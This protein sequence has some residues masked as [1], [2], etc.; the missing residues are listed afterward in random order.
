M[1]NILLGIDMN[2][3]KNM[4]DESQ[5]MKTLYY[6]SEQPADMFYQ[7]CAQ[8]LENCSEVAFSKNQ[9]YIMEKWRS[10]YTH[11]IPVE[12]LPSKESLKEDIIRE[13]P[14]IIVIDTLDHAVAGAFN[15]HQAK[16]D[17]MIA[18]QGIAT[19]YRKKFIVV[20]QIGRADSRER[21]IDLFSGK[22]SG[23]IENQSRKVFS[24][25]PM[26]D[27][28]NIKVIRFLADS[29]GPL[30]ESDITM[31]ITTSRRFKRIL[32]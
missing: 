15:D 11:I 25:F 19:V 13:D 22:G 21:T 17:L 5:L 28:E 16:Q 32:I 1:K 18:M 31:R 9:E 7:F 14:D 10:R 6:S 24:I 26:K 23:S 8:I 2:S 4:I 20:S 27:D 12:H 30:P 29:Y 3:H